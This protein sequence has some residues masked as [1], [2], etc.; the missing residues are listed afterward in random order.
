M[1]DND[2][3]DWTYKGK[4]SL[5]GWRNLLKEM[6]PTKIEI[7][8]DDP[9]DQEIADQLSALATYSANKEA[10]QMTDDEKI[11]FARQ[12]QEDLANDPDLKQM[13]DEYL[14]RYRPVP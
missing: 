6:Q 5:N 1:S 10:D 11:A 14:L 7:I 2:E 3:K 8:P 4:E 13:Y 12:F 9:N